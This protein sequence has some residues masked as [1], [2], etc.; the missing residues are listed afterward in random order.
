MKTKDQILLQKC[1]ESVLVESVLIPRKTGEERIKNYQ[2]S[3]Q[4]R[5][6]KNK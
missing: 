5:I 4:K 1:Y 6:Q 2:I 3:I